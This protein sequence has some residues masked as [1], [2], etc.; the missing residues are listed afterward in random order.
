MCFGVSFNVPR[1]RRNTTVN[2]TD[3]ADVIDQSFTEDQTLWKV[4]GLAYSP[5]EK[6]VIAYYYYVELAS[7]LEIYQ[8]AMLAT[9]EDGTSLDPLQRS[10]I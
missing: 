7:S 9:M 2:P 6:Q 8:E 4:L 10:L 3:A 1:S 5:G